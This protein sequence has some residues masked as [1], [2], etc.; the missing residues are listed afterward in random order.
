MRTSKK[1]KKWAPLLQALAKLPPGERCNILKSISP[2]LIATISECTDNLLRGAVPLSH[3]QL[4]KLKRHRSQLHLLANQQ[5]GLGKKRKLLCRKQTG[6]FLSILLAPLAGILGT[7][8][9]D[10]ISGAIGAKKN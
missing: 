6:G 1:L 4:G 2:E 3:N 9:G 8:V 5:V 7:V 10:L